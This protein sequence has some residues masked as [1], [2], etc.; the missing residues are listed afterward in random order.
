MHGPAIAFTVAMGAF[1]AIWALSLLLPGLVLRGG[2]APFVP[3]ATPLF[4]WPWLLPPLTLL[5]AVM[6][7]GLWK[8]VQCSDTIDD[9]PI[10]DDR[11]PARPVAE[12][13]AG[14]VVYGNMA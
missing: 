13:G 1:L 10:S 7:R 12:D 8:V 2:D 14:G 6:R 5:H 9:Q 4:L 11:S 3:L